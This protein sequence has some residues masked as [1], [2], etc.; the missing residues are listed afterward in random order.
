MLLVFIMAAVAVSISP[1]SAD[2]CTIQPSSLA[3]TAPQNYYSS[4]VIVP[5][6][7]T[8]SFPGGQ[9]SI[10][11]EA[12][13]TSTNAHVGSAGAVLSAAYGINTYTGQLVFNLPPQVIGH[14]LQISISIYGYGGI[15][16]S[17]YGYSNGSPL[18]T[19]VETVKV[20]ST[21]YYNNYPSYNYPNC[22]YNNNCAQMYNSP[23]N[24]NQLQCPPLSV[25]TVQCIGNSNNYNNFYR[26][27]PANSNNYY[28]NYPYYNNSNCYYN[29]CGYYSQSNNNQMQC[30][31]NSNNYYGYYPYYNNPNCYYNNCGYNSQGNNNQMQCGYAICYYNNICNQMYNTCQLPVYNN[32]VQCV[33]VLSKNS[34]ACVILKIPL[35]SALGSVSYQYYALQNLPSSYPAI[36]TWVFVAG[37]FNQGNN[38]SPTGAACPGNYI[39]VALI[40]P[41]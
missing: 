16:N 13:D 27:N 18:T 25:N 21:N 28:S 12:T 15:N 7:A 22:Y 38:S 9:L 36:G 8:C 11:G 14:T 33:G 37:Q 30:V 32:Q 39:N 24:N 5:V 1:V 35:Y 34:S 10:V 3:Y 2:P 23:G 41:T 17:I 19:S 20:T 40:T 31:G 6:S 29:N 26:S 4:G